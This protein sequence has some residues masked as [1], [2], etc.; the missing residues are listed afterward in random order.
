ML[1]LF[2]DQHNHNRPQYPLRGVT[3]ESIYSS[4]TFL[5]IGAF[6]FMESD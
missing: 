6:L 5:D 2:I 4:N 3:C 1:F